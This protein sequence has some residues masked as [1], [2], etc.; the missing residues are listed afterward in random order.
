MKKRLVAAILTAAM[1]LSLTACGGGGD[2]GSSSGGGEQYYN[3]YLQ[4][5][6]STLDSIKGNDNY[7]WKI[8][9]NTMEPLTRLAEKDGEQVRE[10]AGAESW[11]PNEDGTVWTFKLRDNKWSDGKA[12]TA[13]DYAYGILM[14]AP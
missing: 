1:A 9:M 12:V 6:P 3:I 7:S 2:K 4:T 13:A 5:E 10:G 14:R 8:L 11:E